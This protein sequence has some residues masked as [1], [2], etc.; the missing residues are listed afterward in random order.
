MIITEDQLVEWINNLSGLLITRKIKNIDTFDFVKEVDTL[1][2][3]ITGY[4]Q[5]IEHFFSIVINKLKC[6]HIVL[7]IIETDDVI[8]KREWLKNDK[9]CHIFTW[10]KP[11]HHEKLSCIPIGLNYNRQYNEIKNWL[12]ENNIKEIQATKTKIL[13]FNCNL[14]TSPERQK[15]NDMVKSKWSTFCDVLSFYKYLKQ[16]YIPSHIEGKIRIDVTNPK[17][18]DDWRD[19]KFILSP[20]GAGLDC[21]RTWEAILCGVIPIVKS[22]TIDEVFEKLPVLIVE[23]WDEI[24]DIFLENSYINIMKKMENNEYELNRVSL[25]YWINK[26]SKT[27]DKNINK[28][29]KQ[30][31]INFITYGNEKY[32]KAKERLCKEAYNSGFFTSVKG[33]GPNDL[34]ENFKTKYNDILKQDRGGGYWLWKP[35]IMYNEFK[36]MK[37]G[38]YL[39]YMD[40]G[41]IVNKKGKERFNQYIDMLKNSDYGVLSFQMYNQIEKWWTTREIFDYFKMDNNGDYANTGQYIHTVLILKKNKHSDEYIKKLVAITLTQS[42][43]YTDIHNTNG[44]QFNWFKDNRHD[45]SI[46]SLLR[47]QHGSVIIQQDETFIVPFGGNESLKYP[48]WAARSKQ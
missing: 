1:L 20:Q 21:H 23:D 10:N 26:I 29:N 36:T 19:Y 16:Y 12:T 46:S 30:E 5:I 48:F 11:F 27:L 25:D 15:L 24:T 47:K 14:F 40:A 8:L 22:S 18:Y 33:F 28:L 7:V 3:G 9:L 35:I 44:R 39:V 4:S 31:V 17:C 45:Q 42:E 43:L 38:D 34:P 37:E 13:C 32:E 2:V 6:S 41:C